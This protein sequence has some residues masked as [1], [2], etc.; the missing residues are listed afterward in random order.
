MPAVLDKDL[1]SNSFSRTRQGWPQ[2]SMSVFE[3]IEYSQHLKALRNPKPHWEQKLQKF[4][5]S[6]VGAKCPNLH[7]S[8]GLSLAKHPYKIP[9][10]YFIA[11]QNNQFGLTTEYPAPEIYSLCIGYADTQWSSTTHPRDVLKCVAEWIRGCAVD[12]NFEQ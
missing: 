3:R 10:K 9:G 5:G 7:M 2:N 1:T 11:L 4:T 12:L 6:D 8:L